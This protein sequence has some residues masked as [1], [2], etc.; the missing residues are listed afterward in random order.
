MTNNED[1][2]KF[3]VKFKQIWVGGG[4]WN[5]NTVLFKVFHSFNIDDMKVLRG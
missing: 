1:G 4:A 2:L 3:A 5:Q